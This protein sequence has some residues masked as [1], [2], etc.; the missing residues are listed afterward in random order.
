M[1]R[2]AIYVVNPASQEVVADG[3]INLGTIVRRFG[4]NL[5][6]M[7]NGIRVTGPGYYSIDGSITLTPAAAGTVTVTAYKDGVAIPGAVASATVAAADTQVSLP[8][9]GVI[10]ENCVCCDDSS[11]VTFVLSGGDST[12]TNVAIEI[13]KL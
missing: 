3:V 1:S 9:V 2:S 10:K 8:L 11:S 12:V 7:G 5:Q 4:C 6:L 13:E